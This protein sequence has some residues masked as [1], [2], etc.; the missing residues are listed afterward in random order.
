[1]PTT[2]H[3]DTATRDTATRD[4]ADLDAADLDAA[5]TIPAPR[6]WPRRAVIAGSGAAL[7][8][9]AACGSSSSAAPAASTTATTSSAATSSATG[10]AGGATALASVSDVPADT[11]LIVTAPS[12][13]VILAKANGKVVAHTAVCT[14]Q[15]AI[16]D[17]SGVCPLH[18]SKFNVSTGAVI[19]GP[20]SS[21]L[22][23]VSVTET[24]GK[25]FLA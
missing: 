4:P 5:S 25:V 10:A 22:A 11:G 17:G 21:P 19:E 1:M 7:L 13:Q 8:A 16:I 18:G 6:T 3:R 12:G 24:G 9:C 20:A 23:A 2:A 15:G 14:H